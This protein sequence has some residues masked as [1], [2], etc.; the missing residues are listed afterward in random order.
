MGNINLEDSTSV[1]GEPSS[2]LFNSISDK[3]GARSI[4]TGPQAN[5]DGM[6]EEEENEDKD[7]FDDDRSFAPHKPASHGSPIAVS[8]AAASGNT[9]S[10]TAR[11]KQHG[12]TLVSI[13][14]SSSN[15]IGMQ[16]HA[17]REITLQKHR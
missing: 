3:G 5:E 10:K 4:H 16:E 7:T 15:A 14:S 1:I 6:R 17:V 13:K 12:K 8:F 9:V 11:S 2:I